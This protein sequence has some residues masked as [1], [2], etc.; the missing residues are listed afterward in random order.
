MFRQV[1]IY[2]V[3]CIGWHIS[4]EIPLGMSLNLCEHLS[5]MKKG[6]SQVCLSFQ[7]LPDE[8]R[9]ASFSVSGSA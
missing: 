1:G 8:I 4:L 9:I 7:L 6:G 3:C 5:V 2:F